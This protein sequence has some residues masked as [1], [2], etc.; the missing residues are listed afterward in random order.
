MDKQELEKCKNDCYNE[1]RKLKKKLSYLE[2]LKTNLEN[3][4]MVLRNK[5][6]RYDYQLAEIDG[7]LIRLEQNGQVKKP[8]KTNNPF[9][10][11]SE[12]DR[13]LLINSL[14]ELNEGLLQ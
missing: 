4:A 13:L 10:N 8:A 9:N 6:T 11:M 1:L 12:A 14:K 5:F 2:Q 3:E 7:R